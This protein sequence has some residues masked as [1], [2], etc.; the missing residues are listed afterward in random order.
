MQQAGYRETGPFALCLYTGYMLGL[1]PH[2]HRTAQGFRSG[3][4][5]TVYL[6][7]RRRTLR[8]YHYTHPQRVF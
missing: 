4:N 1:I 2:P 5:P 3:A 7:C 6:G 8:T